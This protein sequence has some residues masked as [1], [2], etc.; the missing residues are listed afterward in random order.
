MR[1]GIKHVVIYGT[2][3]MMLYLSSFA[4][5][6]KVISLPDK[7]SEF[8]GWQ[9][10]KIK[11]GGD[12]GPK[13]CAIIFPKDFGYGDKAQLNL[14]KRLVINANNIV[15]DVDCWMPI[16]YFTLNQIRYLALERQDVDAALLLVDRL[17]HQ[18][19][20]LDGELEAEYSGEYELP[21]LEKF[22]DI[23]SIISEKNASLL[24]DSVCAWAVPR[25]E[26][27][28]INKLVDHLSLEG[29][30]KISNLIKKKCD[31]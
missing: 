20:K 14:L 4:Y 21:V 10:T 8:N 31:M 6:D 19:L 26:L 16:D 3:A 17:N 7:K 28:R 24:S 18:E 23:K 29:M 12:C 13:C 9:G 30:N 22:K 11:R 1:Y 27:R 15:H 2:A 5:A 25:N